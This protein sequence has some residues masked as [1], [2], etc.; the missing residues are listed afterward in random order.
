MSKNRTLASV[1][2]LE[3]I[4]EEFSG[5]KIACDPSLVLR[6]ADEEIRDQKG[7]QA[8]SSESF[9]FKAMTL[10]E[11]DNGVL[12]T[13]AVPEQYKT[14]AINMSCNLQKEFSCQSSAEKALVEVVTINYIRTLDI[15]RRINNYLEKGSITDIGV[16]F[17]NVMSK[18][19]DRATRHYIQAVE[20]LKTFKQPATNLK[21]NANTAVVGQN[22]LIQ[23]VNKE[24]PPT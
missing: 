19:L 2:T 16:K 22:Q 14:L 12:L 10:C 8:T 15:Q 17:L 6:R 13:T 18:E 21:I 7:E 5:V 24:F 9:I 20:A 23:T 11:F 1:K 3:Q 4:K